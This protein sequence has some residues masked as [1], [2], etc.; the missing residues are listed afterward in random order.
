MEHT[1]VTVEQ[2][3]EAQE[4][5]RSGLELHES[6]S[7]KEAI[8]LFKKCA[9]VNPYEENHLSELAKKLKAGSYKLLQEC[10][11]YMGCAAVHLHKLIEELDDEEKSR[12]P[13]DESLI[14]VFAEWDREI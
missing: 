6:K 3:R 10:A 14:K 13:L 4:Y 9:S 2:V 5:F 11:A 7:F 8:D 12:V 1:P